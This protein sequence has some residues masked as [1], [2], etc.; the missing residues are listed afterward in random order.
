MPGIL[1]PLH[2]QKMAFNTQFT[3]IFSQQNWW[4][5]ISWWSGPSHHPPPPF[6][7]LDLLL[8][9]IQRVFSMLCVPEK[10]ACW[11]RMY[12]ESALGASRA[13]L[14]L[15]I[16]AKDKTRTHY[17]GTSC[18]HT[19]LW[20]LLYI[21]A[22]STLSEY[23][24]RH[25]ANGTEHRM[26]FTHHAKIPQNDCFCKYASCYIVEVYGPTNNWVTAK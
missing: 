17:I 6:L 26:N 24:C 9:Y 19:P 16:S 4:H 22:H 14:L 2:L 12:A 5:V 11:F 8:F 25:K 1:V 23:I 21:R 7:I 20:N 18:V 13:N 10:K 3:P 15:R